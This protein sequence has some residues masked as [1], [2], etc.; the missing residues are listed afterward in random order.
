MTIATEKAIEIQVPEEALLK[1]KDLPIPSKE[2]VNLEE[3]LKRSLVTETTQGGETAEG[4]SEDIGGECIEFSF[5]LSEL[6]GIEG[7]I[8]KGGQQETTIKLAGVPVHRRSFE[9]KD[10]AMEQCSQFSVGFESIKI[11]FYDD[12]RCY[13]TRGHIRGWF[14]EEKTWDVTIL[15]YPW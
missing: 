5:G 6:I 7:K 10:K 12:K 3:E 11:C 13:K 15:E 4:L 9:F 14:H 2:E 8:C 1:I